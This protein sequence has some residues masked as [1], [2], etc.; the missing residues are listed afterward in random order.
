MTCPGPLLERGTAGYHPQVCLSPISSLERK[1]LGLNPSSSNYG[2]DI[3]N[4]DDNDLKICT[5][6]WLW[7]E[8]I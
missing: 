4:S 5:E 8:P 1:G 2:K 3:C 7:Q 6:H